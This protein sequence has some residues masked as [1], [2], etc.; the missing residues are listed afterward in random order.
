MWLRCRCRTIGGYGFSMSHSSLSEPFRTIEPLRP[1]RTMEPYAECWC[2]SGKKWKWCHKHRERQ[3]PVATGEAIDRLRREFAEGYCSYPKVAN[4]PCS[5]RIIR[6][7]TV[8][9]RGGLAAIADDGHVISALSAAQDLLKNGGKY[10]PRKVGVKSASTF[11]GFCNRHDTLLFRPAEIGSASLTEE[12]CFLLAF[13]AISYELFAKR[14]LYRH[15]YALRDSDA[16]KPFEEQ[17]YVQEFVHSFGEGVRRGVLDMQRWKDEYD[18]I[19]VERDFHKHAFAAIQFSGVLP[20]AGC[21]TFMPEFDFQGQ[22]LQR[23]SHGTAPHEHVTFNLT[24]LDG[25]SVAVFGTTELAGGPAEQMLNS[26]ASLNDEEKADA[27][28]RC[29]FEFVGNLFFRPSWWDSLSNDDRNVLIARISAG[30]PFREERGPDCLLPDNLSLT[31]GN[32]EFNF[33]TSPCRN[34]LSS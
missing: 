32:G 27:V 11:L 25:R 33:I 22:P 15:T 12:V 20:V 29:A 2:G 13:R 16:G 19:L 10:V 4:N 23:L 31:T 24:V 21:G 6:A 34:S 1:Q 30:S 14:A 5:D 7:H 26:F 9:R 17:C 3:Q 18:S 8:Q 28:V